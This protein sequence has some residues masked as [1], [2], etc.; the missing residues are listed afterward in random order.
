[1]GNE[2]VL[3]LSPRPKIEKKLGYRIANLQGVGARARQEDSFA[4]S[5]AFDVMKIWDEGLFITV[6]DGMGGMRDGKLASE[7]AIQ[8]LRNSFAEMDRQGDLDGQLERSIR[9][10]SREVEAVIGGDGGS[11]VVA[12]IIYKERLS[13]A[14]VGDSYFFLYRDGVLNRLNREHNL[15]QQMFLEEVQDGSMEQKNY[16][17]MDEAVALTQFLGMIGMDDV[18]ASYRPYPLK[19]GDILLLCSDGVGGV[20]SEE[21]IIRA[22]SLKSEQAMC[23]QL[24]QGLVA[25]AKRNQDNYTALIVKC[26]Y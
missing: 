24:E 1:M 13:F 12:G 11:T 21:E 25:H 9:L 22:L 3:P 5:N 19:E 7:T 17:E 26:V 16:R 15:C 20:L 18:D 6:C 4:V 14:S 8:S 2:A 23:Q 10:A